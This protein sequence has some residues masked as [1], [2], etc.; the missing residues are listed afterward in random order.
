MPY[1][2][3]SPVALDLH[4]PERTDYSGADILELDFPSAYNSPKTSSDQSH[5]E[6][7]ERQVREEELDSKKKKTFPIK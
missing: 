1:F 5:M 7:E 4:P 3:V 2:Y 6:L